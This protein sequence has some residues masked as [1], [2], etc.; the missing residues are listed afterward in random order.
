MKNEFPRNKRLKVFK[1]HTIYSI[2]HRH[3]STSEIILYFVIV[4]L[5]SYKIPQQQQEQ[6]NS[7][8]Y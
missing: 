5:S 1:L 8:I 2:Y 6:Q 3:E 7:S 4:S